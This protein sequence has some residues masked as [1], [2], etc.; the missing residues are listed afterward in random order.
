MHK[1]QLPADA[2]SCRPQRNTLPRMRRRWVVG[3]LCAVDMLFGLA[4][5]AMPTAQAANY[6]RAE[7]EQGEPHVLNVREIKRVL[8]QSKKM[9]AMC[10]ER[11]LKHNP[12]LT[13]KVGIQFV[14]GERGLVT[15]AIIAD[16]SVTDQRVT[17]C[18]VRG[19][20]RLVFPP[21][22]DTDVT[23]YTPFDLTPLA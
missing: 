21:P 4:F 8:K 23:V 11:A 14:I 18:I 17:G 15:Q 13:G 22:M 16:S 9:V 6:Q 12:T 19:I 3:V 2:F 20:Q 10:Y 1:P 7:L 5:V